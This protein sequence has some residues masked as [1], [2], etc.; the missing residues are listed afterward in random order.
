[1]IN[2][3]CLFVNL[4]LNFYCF[5]KNTLNNIF[6]FESIYVLDNKL[7]KKNKTLEFYISYFTHFFFLNKK[8]Y[9]ICIKNNTGVCKIFTDLDYKEMYREYNK[10][11]ICLLNK[12]FIKFKINDIDCT[13][14]IKDYCFYENSILDY[15]LF[16]HSIL[17][18]LDNPYDVLNYLDNLKVEYK[19]MDL[20][21]HKISENKT[22]D[23][24]TLIINDLD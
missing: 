15:Y 7:N 6:I 13:N 12:R 19:I 24:L 10:L 23:N 11:K 18:T 9:K 16:N 17:N 2:F 22:T 21:K 3:Y 14:N 20:S 8:Y 1:M 4:F 5:L